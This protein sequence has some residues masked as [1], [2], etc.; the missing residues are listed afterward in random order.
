MI[1]SP[2][3][4]AARRPLF[5]RFMRTLSVE[6]Y[7]ILTYKPIDISFTSPGAT[8]AAPSFGTDATFSLGQ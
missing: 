1:R 8:P 5:C 3:A 2:E 6:I 7:A 4:V